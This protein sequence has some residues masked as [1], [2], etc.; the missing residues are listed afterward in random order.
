MVV[1]EG[2][3]KVLQWTSPRAA[4]VIHYI[5]TFLWANSFP[6]DILN[7]NVRWIYLRIGNRYSYAGAQRKMESPSLPAYPR[8]IMSLEGKSVQEKRN[9]LR[10]VIERIAKK[11]YRRYLIM[12]YFITIANLPLKPEPQKTTTYL[13]FAFSASLKYQHTGLQDAGGATSNRNQMAT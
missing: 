7:N 13:Y 6:K 12:L 1:P 2:A 3:T 10:S 9:M 5:S 8:F 4:C 11:W